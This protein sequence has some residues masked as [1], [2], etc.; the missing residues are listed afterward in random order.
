MR[1]DPPNTPTSWQGIRDEALRRIQSRE[2]PAGAPIPNEAELATQFGCARSTV[3]RALREL[4]AI[5]LIERRRKAGSRVARHPLRK[6]TFEIPIIRHEVESRGGRY[7]YTL[8][9]RN[10]GP[11][12]VAASSRMRLPAGTDMLHMQALHLSDGRPYMHENRWVNPVAAPGIL[13][14]DLTRISANAWLVQNVPYTRGELTL[15]AAAADGPRAEALGC[16]TGEAIFCMERITWI[17]EAPVTLAIQSYAP[18][19][20]MTTAI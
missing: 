13:D 10:L 6:A 18:G 19:H 15:S 7:D 17:G 12:P 2:W 8:I 11:A 9:A 5:G 3:N 1:S 14:I 20:R 4:A 16:T